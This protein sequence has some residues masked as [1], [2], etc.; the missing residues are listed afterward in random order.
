MSTEPAMSTFA[1]LSR[2]V[3]KGLEIFSSE[4]QHQFSQDWNDVLTAM[5]AAQ[6]KKYPTYTDAEV[7]LS[8]DRLEAFCLAFESEQS[9]AIKDILKKLEAQT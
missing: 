4:R 6:N 2:I 9:S 5:Q 8:Q 7:V 1:I 3:L